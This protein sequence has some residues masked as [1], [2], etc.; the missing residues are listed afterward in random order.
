MSVSTDVNDSF[1][2]YAINL[3]SD[4]LLSSAASWGDLALDEPAAAAALPTLSELGCLSVF[5]DDSDWVCPDLVLRKD[6]WTHF[7]VTLVPLGTD[8]G[9]AERHS[10]QWHR[11]RLKLERRSSDFDEDIDQV[12]RRLLKALNAST[13][14][15]VLGAE[16]RGFVTVV[17]ETTALGAITAARE[18]C[19]IRMH[20]SSNEAA[21]AAVAAVAAAAPG[22]A[23]ELRRLNDLRDVHCCWKEQQS[24]GPKIFSVSV[25]ERNTRS[26]GLDVT[27]HSANILAALKLSPAWRV[28]PKT[29]ERELCLIEMKH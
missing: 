6:I 16:T 14:W 3:L 24:A 1:R 8:A 21:P 23:I 4:D 27:Q 20:F 13:K 5:D 2:E 22:P 25:H 7:P 19:I 28:L 12:E 29:H 10:V 18:I 15:D 11:D 17:P 9:G 26:A